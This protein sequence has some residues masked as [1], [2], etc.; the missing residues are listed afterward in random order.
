M[1]SSTIDPGTTGAAK[2]RDGNFYMATVVQASAGKLGILYDDGDKWMISPS[3]FI[4]IDFQTP[5][6][7]GDHVLAAWKGAQMFSGVITVVGEI[8]VTV[9]WDD[10]DPP[11]DVAKHRVVHLPDL[12]PSVSTNGVN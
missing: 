3:D 10:G 2:W 4:P 9:E 11:L 1:F 5:F 8:S 6:A 12:G 7:I